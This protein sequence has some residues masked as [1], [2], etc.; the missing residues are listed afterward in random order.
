MGYATNWLALHLIFEPREP[1][2][3]GPWTL[4]GLFIKRQHEVAGNFADVIAGRVLTGDNVIKHIAEGP[5]RESVM[6]IVEGH[7]EESIQ[8]YER[9]TMV[10]MLVTKDKIAEGKEQMLERV[11]NAD[12]ADSGP[13][14]IF[15]EQT[16]RIHAQLKE[17]LLKLDSE[18]FGG[19]LRPVF[20]KDEWKLILA[21]GV[22]G[23]A[24]GALQVVVL[25]GGF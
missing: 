6:A 25:F 23:T 20:Q 9:D 21:G 17:N 19:L 7:V 8:E 10:A 5:S 18:E 16:P 3:I 22:I 15:A 24:I 4:Q 1:V 14:K 13:V 2:K 11:R 12:L